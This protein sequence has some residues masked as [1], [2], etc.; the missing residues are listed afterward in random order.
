MAING[1]TWDVC[2]PYLLIRG[3]FSRNL[4]KIYICIYIYIHCNSFVKFLKELIWN[5]HYT[6]DQKSETIVYSYQVMEK[7]ILCFEK[8]TFLDK[9]MYNGI[10]LHNGKAKIGNDWR[11]DFGV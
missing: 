7:K 5:L 9:I 11:R 6:D 3:L 1:L 2:I 10:L 4:E 8:N